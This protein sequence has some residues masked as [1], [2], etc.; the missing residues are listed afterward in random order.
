MVYL[1]KKTVIDH[2]LQ[3]NNIF[4]RK[5]GI[6]AKKNVIDHFFAKNAIFFKKKWYI[7]EKKP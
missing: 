2:F 1:Q 3:K 7:C 6:S 4:F 5:N